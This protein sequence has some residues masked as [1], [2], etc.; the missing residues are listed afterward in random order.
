[1]ESICLVG[2]DLINIIELKT[3]IAS[4][5]EKNITKDCAIPLFL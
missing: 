1:M 4:H 3:L 5:P 2:V